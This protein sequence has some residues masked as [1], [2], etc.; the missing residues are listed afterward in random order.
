MSEQS[1]LFVLGNTPELA[2]LELRQ[3]FPH[4]ERL[5]TDIARVTGKLE[6]IQELQHRLGGTIKIAIEV[7]RLPILTAEL[8][9]PLLPQQESIY[10]GLSMYGSPLPSSLLPRI[11]EQLELEG[12]HVR[13]SVP[14]H[15]NVISSVTVDK[16][17][18][19]ELICVY[20]SNVYVVGTTV[21]VQDYEAWSERDYGRP[22]SDPKSGMLPP[23]VARMIV[24]IANGLVQQ[25]SAHAQMTVLD[26]FC[27]MGTIL[28]ESYMMGHHVIG[29]DVDPETVRKAQANLDWI[30]RRM[31]NTGGS[32]VNMFTTDAVHIAEKVKNL[33]VSAIV[34]EP[35][36]GS[37]AIVHH[38]EKDTEKV[39]NIIKGLEKLYIGCLRE[40]AR[41][42]SAGS[43]VVIAL[44][45][46][47]IGGRTYFVKKVVDMCENLGYTTLVGPIEYG[48]PQ[49]I[50]KRKFFV[51]QK[52]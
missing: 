33:W 17:G 38:D 46:Y 14:R 48:R 2:L 24:N 47:S 23:K 9:C 21:A 5:A 37:T 13:Y 3:F 10:F 34:T 11:K 20:S 1:Y 26:P 51:F 29:A 22:F 31:P 12:K 40:W 50:V 44:P 39:K 45:E 15:G 32:V 36:M 43:T 25:D 28:A 18:I 6:N 27:G 42:L 49:A 52:K 35:F 30:A 4:A 7:A 16:T 19:T 41:F 8:L